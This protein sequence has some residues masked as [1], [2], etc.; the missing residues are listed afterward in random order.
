[1]IPSGDIYENK[2]CNLIG[3]GYFMEK[4]WNLFKNL[5]VL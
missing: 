4:T 5:L 3:Q 1:M 2:F